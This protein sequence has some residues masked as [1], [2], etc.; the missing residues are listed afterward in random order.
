MSANIGC[1]HLAKI[2]TVEIQRGVY[3]ITRGEG[4]PSF[5]MKIHMG[6]TPETIAYEAPVAMMHEDPVTHIVVPEPDKRYYFAYASADGLRIITA[7]R[8]VLMDGALNFRDMG[9]YETLDGRVLKWGRLF[10]SDS[11]V[12]ISDRDQ[13]RMTYMGI[14]KAYDFRTPD[15]MTIAP[16]RYPESV[17]AVPV[18]IIH[19]AKDPK[20][21]FEDMKKGD[22]SGFDEAFI[23]SRYIDMIERFAPEWG[24]ALTALAD[25]AGLPAVI[26]CTAGKDRT[27][28]M[29]ALLLLALDV[30][31]KTVVEDYLLSNLYIGE[32]K[33]EI[34]KRME[35]FGIDREKAAPGLMAPRSAIFALLNHLEM[36]YGSARDYLK[37][38]GGVTDKTF[39]ELKKNLTTD[40]K[41]CGPGM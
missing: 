14:R 18:P 36:N 25:P 11:L 17:E 12:R 32:R 31:E 4:I 19:G 37:R 30:P 20:E 3:E 8:R 15:E 7:D 13:A 34:L 1:Y 35:K 16:G 38:M 26:H 5:E 39:A 27:G 41:S 23:K 6:E 33:N 28:A 21:Q 9:G 10:R 2:K 40:A 24:K 29:A 22:Y